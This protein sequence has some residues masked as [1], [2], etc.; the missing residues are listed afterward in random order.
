M[1][2]L[3]DSHKSRFCEVLSHYLAQQEQGNCQRKRLFH[4]V[5]AKVLNTKKERQNKNRTT[6]FLFNP[7]KRIPI[8]EPTHSQLMGELLSTQGSHGQ[9]DL[10]LTNFLSRIGIADPKGTW[11]V[12]TELHNI[13]ICLTRIEPASVVI[14]ENKSNWAIDQQSQL[15]RY[16]HEAIYRKHPDL[17][18]ASAATQDHFKVVY[19]APNE[20][21]T[22]QHQSLCRPPDSAYYDAP[23]DHLP[24]TP[25]IFTLDV[26]LPQWFNDCAAKLDESNERLRVFLTMYQEIWKSHS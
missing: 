7:F 20:N 15:Y 3:S 17:D 1:E 8:T 26:D 12:R 6:S 23:H 21:K 14:I 25:I 19:L 18:Y 10:F 9:G 13:D 16:W 11:K 24:L 2:A 5:L 4:E 22:P